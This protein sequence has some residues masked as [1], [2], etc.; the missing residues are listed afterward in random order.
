M[1][2]ALVLVI[3][4]CG[5][6]KQFEAKYQIPEMEPILFTQPM[7]LLHVDYVGMEVTVGLKKSR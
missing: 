6:C 5:C 2:N 4:N 1:A 7:E 3:Q